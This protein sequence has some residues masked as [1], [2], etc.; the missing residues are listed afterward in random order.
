MDR[1]GGPVVPYICP[2]SNHNSISYGDFHPSG[3][4]LYLS[5]IKP[6]L[7]Y[8][9]FIQDR[10]VPYICPT[11]NHN[12]KRVILPM[13]RLFLISV[14]HQ[15]TTGRKDT[16]QHPKLFLISVLHQTTTVTFVLIPAKG[17]FLISVL[18]QTTTLVVM[19]LHAI[20]LFLI[21]VLHQTTTY[22]LNFAVSE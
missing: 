9:T 18:H 15:T 20:M 5:Y 3:C 4:S 12:Q 1:K 8:S 13:Q 21:S 22:I 14:L 10:V 16:L 6:Q 2:T 19:L 11:S 17:L 7:Y